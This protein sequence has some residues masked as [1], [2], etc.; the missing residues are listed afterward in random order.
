M[1]FETAESFRKLVSKIWISQTE[2]FCT[3]MHSMFVWKHNCVCE[4]QAF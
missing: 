4:R 1:V 2:G 3:K